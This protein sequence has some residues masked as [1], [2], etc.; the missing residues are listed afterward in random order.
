MQAVAVIHT[1]IFT[2]ELKPKPQKQLSK[3]TQKKGMEGLER[4]KCANYK[5]F[6]LLSYN[7]GENK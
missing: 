5:M 1:W 6:K 4:K 7:V 3:S 2:Y